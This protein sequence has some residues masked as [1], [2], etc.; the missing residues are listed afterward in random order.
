MKTTGIF[1]RIL[2]TFKSLSAKS[3]FASLSKLAQITWSHLSWRK[4][5][6]SPNQ[7]SQR[8]SAE[9]LHLFFVADFSAGTLT[10]KKRDRQFFSSDKAAAVWNSR[11]AGKKALDAPHKDGY[12][13][14]AIFRKAYLAHRV[15]FAMKTGDWPEY[16]DHINGNRA[17]NSDTNLR[18]ATKVENGCN[19]AMPHTNTSGHI[20]VSWNG[21]D[22]RWTAYITMH[23]KRKALGNF[24]TI[25]EAVECRKSYERI[26]GFH[27]NHGRA[28]CN[29]NV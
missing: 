13:C 3:L 24:K 27:P 12:K 22:K 5:L 29:A 19:A 4:K 10:W 1:A 16:V 18:Q 20:G 6:N 7:P 25:D 2:T 23:Q 26:Y 21:R 17:D 9:D 14:G 28:S 15:L 11:F 8:L